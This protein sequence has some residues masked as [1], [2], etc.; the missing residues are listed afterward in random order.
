M[1]HL[2]A[3][4]PSQW[5]S[6]S[7]LQAK[8]LKQTWRMLNHWNNCCLGSSRSLK[9]MRAFF[10][11]IGWSVSSVSVRPRET[12]TQETKS[13]NGWRYHKFW[14][15]LHKICSVSW[16]FMPLVKTSMRLLWC[17]GSRIFTHVSNLGRPCF[18]P[19]SMEE[20]LNE[21]PCT[22]RGCDT[23]QYNTNM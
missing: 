19:E 8:K 7:G 3:S 17:Y 23:G 15:G 9:N 2:E 12:L 16:C 5:T 1:V 4:H 13:Q 20:L 21:L 22:P 14:Y 10:T 11:L 6:R 18:F